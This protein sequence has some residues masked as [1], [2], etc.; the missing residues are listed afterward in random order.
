[1]DGDR[2]LLRGWWNALERDGE[3][4]RVAADEGDKDSSAKRFDVVADAIFFLTSKSCQCRSH[5]EIPNDIT[6]KRPGLQFQC[7]CPD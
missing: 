7:L 3:L 4:F 1:M 5:S 6:R 2:H